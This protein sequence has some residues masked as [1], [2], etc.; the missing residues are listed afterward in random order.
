MLTHATMFIS[1]A[2]ESMMMQLCDRL[3]HFWMDT[4]ASSIVTVCLKGRHITP[5]IHLA[6]AVKI[7]NASVWSATKPQGK[8]SRNERS[9]FQKEHPCGTTLAVKC[10]SLVGRQCQSAEI[11]NHSEIARHWRDREVLFSLA[12][13]FLRIPLKQNC[14]WG[15]NLLL[16]FQT[17]MWGFICEMD[18]I[19]H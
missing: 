15:C 12:C 17:S 7:V 8:V 14:T 19:W 10:G 6:S 2:G 9:R 3:H 1:C 5:K 16:N 13:C 4:K 11:L 18:L